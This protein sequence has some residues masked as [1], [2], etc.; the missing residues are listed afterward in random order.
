MNVG[1]VSDVGFA[2]DH[3]QII[4]DWQRRGIAPVSSD[5]VCL[6]IGRLLMSGRNSLAFSC[7]ADTRSYFQAKL[8]QRKRIGSMFNL[9]ISCEG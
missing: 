1:V 6:A 7:K 2:A 8:S 3:P 9:A 5:K 4:R